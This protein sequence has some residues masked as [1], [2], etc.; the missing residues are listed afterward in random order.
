MSMRGDMSID[1]A[2]AALSNDFRG[3]VDEITEHADGGWSVEIRESDRYG[4]DLV[5]DHD[6]RLF[7]YSFVQISNEQDN[8]AADYVETIL[9]AR[10]PQDGRLGLIVECLLTRR[11]GRSQGQS[12]IEGRVVRPDPIEWDAALQM[13]IN[14][15]GKRTLSEQLRILRDA[16]LGVQYAVAGLKGRSA[17]I[18]DGLESLGMIGRSLLEVEDVN[19]AI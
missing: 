15:Y 7:R 6:E 18:G 4:S 14:A 9:Q 2:I 11:L 8:E 16:A 10:P 5:D 13:M 17:D 1:R 3:T 19:H 12:L